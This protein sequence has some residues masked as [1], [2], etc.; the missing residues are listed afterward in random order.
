MI[1]LTIGITTYERPELFAKLLDSIKESILHDFSNSILLEVIVVD[2]SSK[3]NYAR[4]YLTSR[5]PKRIKSITLSGDGG[6]SNGRNKILE[7]AKGEWIALIDDD[8]ALEEDYFSV[9][10]SLISE[11]AS[12]ENIVG[13]IG[14]VIRDQ[15][16]QNPLDVA[17]LKSGLDHYFSF[18]GNE[19]LAERFAQSRWGPTANIIINQ[20]YTQLFP[21]NYKLPVGGEDVIWGMNITKNNCF[22]KCCPSLKVR[23]SPILTN[24]KNDLS[25]V[26]EKARRYGRSESIISGLFPSFVTTYPISTIVS[27]VFWYC[28]YYLIPHQTYRNNINMMAYIIKANF[29]IGSL[30]QSIIDRKYPTR[31][32]LSKL[33]QTF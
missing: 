8:C 28:L 14:N 21:Y 5:L 1:R 17:Y 9:V 10:Y 30:V 26:I 15:C 4:N 29:I 24:Q 12:E 20:R 2:N 6:A 23:H 18:T 16:L 19:S 27:S 22:F 25:N 31:V 32:S 33:S 11:Y 7:R 13:F 3:L